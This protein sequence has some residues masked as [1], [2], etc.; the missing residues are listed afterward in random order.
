GR[1]GRRRH[2]RAAR[3]RD[4]R[5]G[6]ARKAPARRGLVP[7]DLH[8]PAGAHTG[9]SRRPDSRGGGIALVNLEHIRVLLDADAMRDLL[10]AIPLLADGTA[11]LSSLSLDLL[12]VK[13]WR[14]FPDSSRV[15]V[16]TDGGTFAIIYSPAHL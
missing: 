13:H 16:A 7:V 6:N 1:G 14:S 12:W 15:D 10:G 5:A 3:R 8:A 9:P 2:P 4:P 11:G